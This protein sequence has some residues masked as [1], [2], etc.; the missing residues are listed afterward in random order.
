[1]ETIT[2][3]LHYDLE[4]LKDIAKYLAGIN[5][6]IPRYKRPTAS[7]R[8]MLD[9]FKKSEKSGKKDR[10]TRPCRRRRRGEAAW[11]T[12]LGG[13]GERSLMSAGS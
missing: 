11:T 4:P 6:E 9:K 3:M 12:Y 8:A 5:L 1:M 2:M 13:M 10:A 7:P